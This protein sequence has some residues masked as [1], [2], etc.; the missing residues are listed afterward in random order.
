MLVVSLAPQAIE[1]RDGVP[2]IIRGDE[3][4]C[5][6]GCTRLESFKKRAVQKVTELA[7]TERDS[8]VKGTWA[9]A[10]AIAN[11]VSVSVSDDG[12]VK[13]STTRAALKYHDSNESEDQW[14]LALAPV[15]CEL[16]SGRDRGSDTPSRKAKK[17]KKSTPVRDAKKMSNIKRPR[18]L[19]GRKRAL[20][21]IMIRSQAPRRTAIRSSRIQ[22]ASSPSVL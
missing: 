17:R 16:Y 13:R 4:G 9:A 14:A 7:S 12:K 10:K 15:G 6:T 5:P 11:D 19:R 20:M 22:S 18:H 3:H 1:Y 8:D 21:A 2:G